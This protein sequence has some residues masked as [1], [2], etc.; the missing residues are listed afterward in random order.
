MAASPGGR[1][2][3]NALKITRELLPHFGGNVIADFSLPR[4]YD[5]FS[6]EGLKDMQLK[7]DLN[8]KVQLFQNAL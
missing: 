4:F 8:Q 1:G 7:E 3:A 5:N 2:G 6:P